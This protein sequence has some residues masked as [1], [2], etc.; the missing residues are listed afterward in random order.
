MSIISS[1]KHKISRVFRVTVPQLKS[2]CSLLLLSYSVCG[3]RTG[4][5]GRGASGRDFDPAAHARRAADRAFV[6]GPA[7]N[8]VLE[9]PLSCDEGGDSLL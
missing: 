3:L 5:D 7:Q 2:F 6:E 8:R 9:E 4:R 1:V